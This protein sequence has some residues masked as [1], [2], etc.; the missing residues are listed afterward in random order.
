M[1]QCIQISTRI[2]STSVHT[3]I[4]V[5]FIWNI[6]N[7][8]QCHTNLCR[9]NLK[10]R[11]VKFSILFRWWTLST[12]VTEFDMKL[13]LHTHYLSGHTPFMGEYHADSMH[14]ALNDWK[15]YPIRASLSHE[16]ITP[17]L[18]A[19]HSPG[20]DWQFLWTNQHLALSL[21]TEW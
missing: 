3:Y 7:I 20:C 10:S 15:W 21:F 19:N 17:F 16:C 6:S 2:N 9:L 18:V 4:C 14:H 8:Q 1:L 13:W 5:C 12:L 11:M